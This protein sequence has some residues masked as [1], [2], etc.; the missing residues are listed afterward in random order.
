MGDEKDSKP[1]PGIV[2]V[3]KKD[4]ETV[5]VV[6]LE[7]SADLRAAPRTESDLF[8]AFR[9][10][11]L[12][13][14][15]A[16]EIETHHAQ[17]RFEQSRK[18]GKNSGSARGRANSPWALCAIELSQKVNPRNPDASSR[19]VAKQMLTEWADVP[20]APT[21]IPSPD[22]LKRFVDDLKRL[23]NER[24]VPFGDVLERHEAGQLVAMLKEHEA[25]RAG[26]KRL[27]L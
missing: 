12:K 14:P 23:A 21:D 16:D 10:G 13:P 27:M 4:G 9:L 5:W 8:D 24:G 11:M 22:T 2:A 19:T 18:G 7:R 3:T 17:G 25:L 20:D 1:A 15:S 6:P 26:R